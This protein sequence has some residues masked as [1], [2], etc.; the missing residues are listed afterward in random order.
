MCRLST[1]YYYSKDENIM[2]EALFDVKGGKVIDWR[3]HK[4]ESLSLS[5]SFGR[6]GFENKAERVSHCGDLLEFKRYDSG[7]MNLHRANFCKVRLCP[8]CS[9]RRSLKIFGQV[10][11]VMNYLTENYEYRY[12]F[13][14]LTVKNVLGDKL[15]SELDILFKAFNLLTKRKEF[16]NVSQGWFR[17]LE[18]THNWERDDYH[19]H[20]HMVVAVNKSYF[21]YPKI[22]LSQH[23][24]VELWKS[25]LGVDYDPIVWVETVKPNKGD[26]NNFSKGVAEV[27]KYAVKSNDYLVNIPKG[28]ENDIDFVN[29]AHAITDNIVS[30]IDFALRNR[31]L[32]A[33]GGKFKEV[34]KLLNLDDVEN[35]DLVNT[36]NDDSIRD[37]LGYIIVKYRWNCGYKDYYKFE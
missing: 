2:Q 32:V 17:C 21:S 8:M 27:A 29:E 30:I 18:V 34:H 23:N 22:Y 20:F 33:H 37:D 36:D 10:S 6:I 1:L 13:L 9:W 16:K 31:R 26:A 28:K 3:S 24:W 25:C 5:D 14:T 7:D 12:I 19:P 15:S 4:M 11:N 35:G